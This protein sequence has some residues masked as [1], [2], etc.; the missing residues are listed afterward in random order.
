MRASRGLVLVR[1]VETSERYAGGHIIIPDSAREKLA[2]LQVEIVD[3]GPD[4]LC[5]DDDCER[6]HDHGEDGRGRACRFHPFVVKIGAWALITAHSQVE[7]DAEAK[8]W[9]VRQDDVVAI[10]AP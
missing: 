5:E 7:V 3:V 4:A 8:L 1:P 9:C 6:L 10:L 2:A